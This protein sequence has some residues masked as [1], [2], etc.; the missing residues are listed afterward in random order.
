MEAL[1]SGI[2][3]YIEYRYGRTGSTESDGLV[4]L[5]RVDVEAVVKVTYP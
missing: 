5:W 3:K 2:N 1:L 4:L